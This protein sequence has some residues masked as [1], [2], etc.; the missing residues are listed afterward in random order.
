M[1]CLPAALRNTMVL[2]SGCSAVLSPFVTATK[3]KW[4]AQ[5]RKRIVLEILWE[6]HAWVW[7]RKATTLPP[8]ASQWDQTIRDSYQY[9][10]CHK[11]LV[12]KYAMSIRNDI[13]SRKRVTAERRMD[14]AGDCSEGSRKGTLEKTKMK[15]LPASRVWRSGT[16]DGILCFRVCFTV[17]TG[18]WKNA[19]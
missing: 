15:S 10:V 8:P 3:L 13:F 2:L 5:S 11:S 19:W 7:N 18:K 1:A 17:F 14:I 4:P 6:N 16:T 12:G 9:N